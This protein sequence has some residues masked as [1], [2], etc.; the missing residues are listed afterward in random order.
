M[1]Q[2]VGCAPACLSSILLQTYTHYI[3]TPEE[4]AK[5]LFTVESTAPF[6]YHPRN[7]RF[8]FREEVHFQADEYGSRATTPG[9]EPSAPAPLIKTYLRF[10]VDNIGQQVTFEFGSEKDCDVSI[11]EPGQ[12]SRKMFAVELQSGGRCAMLKNL[13]APGKLSIES[14]YYEKLRFRTARALHPKDKV[15]IHVDGFTIELLFLHHA[16]HEALHE[17]FLRRLAPQ[18]AQAVP[19]LNQLVLDSM[20]ES[21]A[22]PQRAHPYCF[23]EEVGS[24]AFG[25]VYKAVHSRTG[26]FVAVKR[27]R[28]HES[29]PAALKEAAILQGLNHVSR[30][31]EFHFTA[32]CLP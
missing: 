16:G 19:G 4:Q 27:F 5:T 18:L 25:T 17:A 3:M 21:S 11:F 28:K 13:Q 7:E 29:R 1:L 10:T 24:G 31:L 30:P 32:A 6:I 9:R 26:E 15:T 20:P 12:T 22:Q 2:N 14:P 8:R 23:H